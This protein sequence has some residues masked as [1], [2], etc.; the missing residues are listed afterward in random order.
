MLVVLKI[1]SQKTC[2]ITVEYQNGNN[3]TREAFV[4]T[5]EKGEKT[6]VFGSQQTKVS[7]RLQVCKCFKSADLFQKM[8]I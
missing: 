5:T 6:N 1:R 4:L 3:I 2:Q 8:L 7:K